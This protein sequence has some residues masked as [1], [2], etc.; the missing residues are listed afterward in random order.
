MTDALIAAGPLEASVGP[1]AARKGLKMF[2]PERLP[3][4][5]EMG[6]FCHPDVPD[7]EEV[8]VR[9]LITALGYETAFVGM[10]YDAPED[11]VDAWYEEQDMTAPSRWSPTPPDGDGWTLA[12]KYDTESGPYAMFVRP[13]DQHNRTPRGGGP[14]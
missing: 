2:A 3:Q 11:L 14:G 8:D 6:F 13:N 9:P 4:P 1:H 5:D 7:D 12:A 10:D